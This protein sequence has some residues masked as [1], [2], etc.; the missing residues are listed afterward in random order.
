[1]TDARLTVLDSV[2]LDLT[3]RVDALP[4]RGGDVVS[5]PAHLATGGGF[6]VLVAAQRQGL[7]VRYGGH[8]GAGPFATRARDDLAAAG[9]EVPDVP[10]AGRDLGVCVVLV[11]P[12]GE[13]TFVTAAGAELDLGAEALASLGWGPHEYLYLSGYNFAHRSLAAVVAPW[14]DT[15]PDQVVVALDPGARLGDADPEVVAHALARVDWLLAS[16]DECCALADDTDL[17]SAVTTL[18]AAVRA[19]VV[20]HEGARGCRLATGGTVRAIPG[21]P[22]EVVDSNGA[23]DTHNGV[24][25]ASLADGADP[26]TAAWRANVAASHAIAHVGGAAAPTWSELDARLRALGATPTAG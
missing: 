24:F 18:A 4:A 2:L 26:V 14:L 3:L 21:V 20:V 12:D 6:N 25:L 19:G 23:G 22:G 9:V 5:A 11:E 16:D 13:R 1:M 10:T 7:A 15:L 17:A 8:L